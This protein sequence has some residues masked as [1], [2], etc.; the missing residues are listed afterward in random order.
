MNT[1]NGT[2][3]KIIITDEPVNE[4]KY[5]SIAKYV[6]QMVASPPSLAPG[7][8]VSTAML[9]WVNPWPEFAFDKIS[10]PR[11]DGVGQHTGTITN[12]PDLIKDYHFISLM[13][14]IDIYNA[15]DYHATIDCQVNSVR[16]AGTM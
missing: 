1:N 12:R 10:E 11:Y 16:S 5:H 14:T 9:K 2:S 7:N 13:R 3:N 15:P 6:N 4:Q 8:G